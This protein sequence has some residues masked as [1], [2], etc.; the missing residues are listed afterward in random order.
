MPQMMGS[1]FNFPSLM[2]AYLAVN[3]IPDAAIVVDGPDCALY[4]AHF[5]FGRHDLRST[6]LDI[7]GKHRVCF[8][9]IC[10]Q[11]A[12]KNHSEPILRRLR[13]LDEMAS[14][15]MILL[16]ALPGCSLTGVDY[17]H[18][19][20]SVGSAMKK[21]SLAVPPISLTGDWLDGY[22]VVLRALARHL[23]L[24]GGRQKPENVAL[25]GYLMDRNEGD[26]AANLRELRR[27]LKALGLN[28]VSVWLD[29]EPHEALCHVKDARWIISLPYGSEAAREISKKTGAQLIETWL[30]FGLEAT[31]RWVRQI[32]EATGKSREAL[33]LLR[34][35]RANAL[36]R[37]E[38]IVPH[39]FLHRTAAFLG[40][41][42][43]REGFEGIC[44]ELGMHLRTCLLASHEG[45]TNGTPRNGASEIVHEPD[46]YHP[47][48][49]Q[50]AAEKI[51]LVVSNTNDIVSLIQRPD[52]A[53]VE[54][55]FPSYFHHALADSPYLGFTGFLAF[56]E[57]LADA[58]NS[59]RRDMIRESMK[60]NLESANY[61]ID[62]SSALP[63][64]AR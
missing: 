3:A 25:V 42:F 21:P 26:H 23:D 41:P 63:K 59:K 16:T 11:G 13:L 14:V 29:S 46:I 22:A 28:L 64:R 9:N 17:E 55:G 35:E 27:I 6:L 45:R 50:L 61:A 60:K 34:H 18:L 52:T 7:N 58:L 2:G 53:L 39:L 4:K 38:W 36:D 10:A 62:A 5:I 43:L 8:T 40:D 37:L 56:V 31:E 12:T 48:V 51:D 44:N 54:I 20:R 1:R 49:Q 24:S 57:R 15:G 30:P 19:L 32:A 33:T 47:A